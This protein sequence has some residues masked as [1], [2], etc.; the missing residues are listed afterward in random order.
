MTQGY[1]SD[2]A[3]PCPFCGGAKI[4]RCPNISALKCVDCNV[5]G[6]ATT[7]LG[8]RSDIQAWNRRA[9]PPFVEQALVER[10]EY[11]EAL[12]EVRLYAKR[13]FATRENGHREVLTRI[14][15]LPLEEKTPTPSKA[16]GQSK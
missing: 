10:E 6:P 4:K 11:R 8:G 16:Q 5:V 7:K 14:V 15:E 13:L 2:G 3:L 9:Y 1:V 12:E